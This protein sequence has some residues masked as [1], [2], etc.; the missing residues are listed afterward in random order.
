[1]AKAAREPV[2]KAGVD[3]DKLVEMLVR[4]AAV[5]LRQ[6]LHD[7]AREPHRPRRRGAQGGSPRT[8][9]SRIGTA[10]KTLVPRIYALGGKLP[11]RARS[12]SPASGTKLGAH[13]MMRVS[14]LPDQKMIR[15]LV[16]LAPSAS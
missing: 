16:D 13:C 15:D 14:T 2:E 7:P 4:N 8:R 12:T 3:I 11:R 5:E 6:L 10:S 1:M 9:A